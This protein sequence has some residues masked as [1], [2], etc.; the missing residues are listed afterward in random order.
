MRKLIITCI[1]INTA[2]LITILFLNSYNKS[3][4]LGNN[5]IK[6]IEDFINIDS[7]KAKVSVI[8]KSNKNENRYE[9]EQEVNG[10]HEY[11]K[12]TSPEEL[13][14]VT[15]TYKDRIQ[16]VKNSKLNASKIY[17]EHEKVSTNMLFLTDFLK[18][19][20]EIRNEENATTKIYEKNDEIILEIQT[21]SVYSSTK[22]LRIDKKT[23]KPKSMEIENYNKETRVYILYN[24]I[25]FNI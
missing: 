20:R 8:V 9:I 16:T 2:V 22:K 23:M 25:E 4:K 19:F 13:K 1:F 18:E 21:N 6:E 11:E 5:H 10:D 14:G 15:I 3:S 7:Y 12:F 17:E 24:E